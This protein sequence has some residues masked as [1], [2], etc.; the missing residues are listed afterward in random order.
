MI[1]MK[2]INGEYTLETDLVCAPFEAYFE[3]CLDDFHT[4]YA[5]FALISDKYLLEKSIM[6]SVSN[7]S[8]IMY[9]SEKKSFLETIGETLINLY[10][11]FMEFIDNIIDNIKTYVFNK[12]TDLQKL[13]I[14]LKKHPELKDEAV[15]AFKDGTF[16]LDDVKSLKE[17]D[18]TFEEILKIAKKSNIDPDSLKGKWEKVKLK[19]E[20]NREKIETT[21][22]FTTCVIS[23]AVALKT[24]TSRC[25]D[26]KLRSLESKTRMREYKQEAYRI[27]SDESVI[28]NNTG[29]GTTLLSI[30]RELMGKHAAARKENL[31]FID[32]LGNSIA[33][34]VD[35]LA[36]DNMTSQLHRDLQYREPNSNHRREV[37]VNVRFV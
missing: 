32:I 7:D 8:E 25:S 17:L 18:V 36:S 10:N 31:Q 30:Y 9:E 6:E 24:Y 22:K 29:L 5:N 34:F 14:L 20:K 3:S 4:K 12:K 21:A 13:D 28:D 1:T 11:R 15:M 37:D 2:Y 35:R 26:A 23:A 19:F 27:L 16:T 33:S